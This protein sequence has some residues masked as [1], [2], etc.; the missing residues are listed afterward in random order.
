MEGLE[1]ERTNGDQIPVERLQ[2]AQI[3]DQP[4]AF[5]NGTLV[6]RV[7]FQDGEELV[8]G[9]PGRDHPCRETQAVRL[10]DQVAG[11]DASRVGLRE[12]TNDG[13]P[14]RRGPHRS[15]TLGPG[16]ARPGW[17]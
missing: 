14:F 3:E 16:R 13:A 17:L 11:H 7:R 8:G 9:G 1:A 10:E 15:V 4:M 12:L 5:G 6:E 2:M